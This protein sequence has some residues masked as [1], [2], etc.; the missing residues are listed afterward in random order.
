LT[1]LSATWI[2]L[3]PSPVWEQQRNNGT[4]L[5]EAYEADGFIHCTIGDGR[6]LAV[7][8]MFYTGDR[9]PFLALSLDP[10]RITSEVRFE[11]PDSVFPHIYG[12]LQV[13][14]VTGHRLVARDDEGRFIRFSSVRPAGPEGPVSDVRR[15]LSDERSGR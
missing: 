7:A 3:V 1:D 11:D 6:M 4:Y 12:P 10:A 5:P 8:N 13:A 9:R 14:A 15:S 2:H